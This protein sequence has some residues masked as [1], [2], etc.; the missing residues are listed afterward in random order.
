MQANDHDT[1]KHE[2]RRLLSELCW[3][4]ELGWRAHREVRQRG[5]CRLQLAPGTLRAKL[6]QL[7]G[8]EHRDLLGGRGEGYGHQLG[9]PCHRH[10]NQVTEAPKTKSHIRNNATR[11]VTPVKEY[12]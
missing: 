5:D 7:R 8:L 2:L 3:A 10:I 4:L 6:R 11:C 12:Q 1:D 9:I